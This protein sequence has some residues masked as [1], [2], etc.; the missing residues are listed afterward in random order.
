MKSQKHQLVNNKWFDTL[1]V[2]L[3]GVSS[4]E[5]LA[6]ALNEYDINMFR[7]DESTV[8]LQLDETVQKQ[9]LI[10]LVNVFTGQE[11]YSPD[12]LPAIPQELLRSDEILTNEVFNAHHSE[13]AML[14]YLHSLQRMDLSLADSM[15]PLGSCTMKL[16]ATVEMQTLSIPG[17][18]SIHPFA[19]I[20]QAQGYKELIDEFEKD[21]NDITG[22]D[23]TTSM[24]NSGA[25]GE[26][27][28]LSLIREYHRSRGEHD[29]RNIC[30]IP[31]SAHG[32]NQH[33]L[34]CVD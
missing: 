13:T 30:L 27:T 14:R 6:K 29:Q 17:F 2:K 26:Y 15:I 7:V 32:T 23:G 33:Q 3:N 4:D 21:L 31:V 16:N 5:I 12:E 9:D 18:N 1:T 28:G 22:F 11:N 20:D 25:Q 24:P 8:S 19:P 10:N 34:L